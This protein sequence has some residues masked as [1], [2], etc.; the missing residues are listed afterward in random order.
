MND[1]QALYRQKLSAL[2]DSMPHEIREAKEDSP[3]AGDWRLEDALVALD[4]AIS[5]VRAQVGD[6]A[7]R[8]LVITV[9]DLSARPDAE[10]SPAFAAVDRKRRA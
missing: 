7:A 9:Y 3:L 1:P 10:A 5:S 6:A 2:A 4:A 8:D